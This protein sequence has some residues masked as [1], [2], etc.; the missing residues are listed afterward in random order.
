MAKDRKG[1]CKSDVGSL[2]QVQRE[3]RA[4]REEPWGE[5]QSMDVE[6]TKVKLDTLSALGSGFVTLAALTQRL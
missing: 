4:C 5:E 2:C 3:Q 6:A 1:A